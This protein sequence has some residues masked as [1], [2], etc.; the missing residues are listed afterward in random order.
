MKK[1]SVALDGVVTHYL[2]GGDGPP[3]VFLHG[4]MSDGT[5]WGD[6]PN[7][8]TKWFTVY[9]PDRR[10]H[11]QTPDTDAPFSYDGMVRETSMFCDEVIGEPAHFVGWSDGGIVALCIGMEH[12]EL[13]AR[14]VLIGA[15]FHHDGLNQ[16][17]LGLGDGP[18]DPE[19]GMLKA[20]YCATAVDGPE[21]WD[22]FYEKT[23]WL[24]RNEPTLTTAD[25]HA[26]EVPTLVLVGDDEP[27]QLRHTVELYESIVNGQLCVVPGAS[28]LVPLEQPDLV[29]AVM[30]R[31]LTMDL[32][33]M[34]LDPIR[35]Q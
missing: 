16:D 24:W 29:E 13:V 1:C 18:D 6:L 14:Q 23:A 27:I 17:A 12:R 26:I 22:V 15:N 19:A 25:L 35:R 3:L 4:G 2:T 20:L 33:P 7:R 30:M 8:F 10:G 28:H 34:T 31:F 32:P 5:S 9:V 11:G 21:H